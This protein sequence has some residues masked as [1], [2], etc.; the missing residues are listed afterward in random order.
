MT[1]GPPLATGAPEPIVV[2]PRAVGPILRVT[3]PHRRPL[4]ELDVLIDD[5]FGETT[6]ERPGWFD[7]GLLAV[8]A[9]ALAWSLLGAGPTWAGAIG[10]LLILLGVALPARSVI[11][12]LR[13]R[14]AARRRARAIRQGYALDVS[15]PATEA[16]VDAYDRL[17]VEARG[18]LEL[19]SRRAAEGAHLALVEVAT[20]L[21]GVRPVDP[22]QLEYIEKRTFAIKATTG[23]LARA[24]AA[25]EA[26]Y[27][28]EARAE[29]SFL[30][31]RR[32]AAALTHAREELE[33]DH[34]KTS[35]DELRIV[36]RALEPKADE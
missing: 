20:L 29:A 9:A 32:R 22:S 4:D 15:H 5:V 25:W 1:V 33:A 19:P 16:L 3:G 8:G 11:R 6:T 17:L 13:S 24:N 36:R 12:T 23:A 18:P 28:R 14:Q 27:G 7:I 30:E 34:G 2:V 31:R 21:S 26:T 35:T 10:G